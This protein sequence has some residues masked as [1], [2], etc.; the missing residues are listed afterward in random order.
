MTVNPLAGKPA[1]PAMLVNVP[2]SSRRTT[3]RCPIRRC[4][5]K[6]SPSAL[7]GIAAQR[8][9]DPSTNGISC[10]HPGHL[11][12][13]QA[14]W[15][16]RSIVSRDGYARAVR[17]RDRQRTRG[18]CGE[19]SGCHARGEGRIHADSGSVACNSH[20]QPQA[21]SRP[22]GRHR[23]HPVTQPARTGGFK[24]NPPNG[25][26]A[27]TVVTGWIER[28]ANELL[29]RGLRDVKRLSFAKAVRSPRRIG[30]TI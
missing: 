16:G 25:G 29:D 12:V 7:R 14:A 5:G 21:R 11:R 9:K 22:R 24:Y 15:D 30:T 6:G 4:R 1:Q 17:T 3:T 19:R 18:A 26:P 2:S 20:L 23:H 8:S 28:R 13:P 27:D 10:H